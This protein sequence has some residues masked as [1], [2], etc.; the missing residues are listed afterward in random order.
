MQTLLR[1]A[2]CLQRLNKLFAFEFWWGK[3][4][5]DVLK[6]EGDAYKL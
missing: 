2:V 1:L 3:M 5:E 4:G 6:P